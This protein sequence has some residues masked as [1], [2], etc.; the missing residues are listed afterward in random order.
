MCIRDR[1]K[2]REFLASRGIASSSAA[3]AA[4]LSGQAVAAAPAGVAAATTGAATALAGAAAG[5]WLGFMFTSKLPLTLAAAVLVG[6]AG[7][8]TLQ[9]QASRRAVLEL[10]SLSGQENEISALQAWNQRLAAD[11]QQARSLQDQ[12]AAMRILV[13]QEKALQSRAANAASN[14]AIGQRQDRGNRLEEGATVFDAAKLD[15][16]PTPVKQVRPR[17]PSELGASGASGEVLVDFI[18]GSDGK[19]YNAQSLNGSLSAEALEDFTVAGNGTSYTAQSLKWASRQDSGG[20]VSYTHLARPVQNASP[21]FS[22]TPLSPMTAKRF[23]RG[24]RKIR[25]PFLWGDFAI[26]RRCV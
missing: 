1:A 7:V 2:L 9:E 24:A 21:H 6:G 10:S 22:C 26:P 25:T 3:L 12:E 4:A 14:S 17:F 11:A 19:V 15:R 16:L 13:A 5:G 18:V 8:V 23:E 20:A